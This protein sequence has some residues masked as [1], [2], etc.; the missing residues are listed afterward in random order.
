MAIPGLNGLNRAVRIRLAEAGYARFW[1]RCYRRTLLLLALALSGS[2]PEAGRPRPTGAAAGPSALP[3]AAAI[4]AQLAKLPLAFVPNVGQAGADVRYVSLGPGP[5]LELTDTEVRLKGPAARRGSNVVSLRLAGGA[6]PSRVE[7][8]DEL[9]GKVHHFDSNDPQQWRRDIPTFRR[10]TYRDVYPAT[11]LVFHGSQGAVEFD[12]VLRPG[13][14]PGAIGIDVRGAD[15]VTLD[16]EDVVI[17]TGGDT[18]RMHAP[19]V[20]QDSA[21]GRKLVDG[22][23]S[24][25]GSRIGFEIGAY[26]R[27]KPL[28]IDPVVTYSTYLGGMG[29]D[30][31]VGVGVDAA[32][33]IYT[34]NGFPGVTAPVRE[35]QRRRPDAALLRHPGR[36]AAPRARRRRRRQRVHRQLLP[37]SFP[38]PFHFDCPTRKPLTSPGPPMQRGDIGTYV[39]KLDPTGAIL[40]STSVGGNGHV[41]P[42]GIAIDEAG[43]MYVTAFGPA[44]GSFPLTRPPSAPPAASPRSSRPS[45]PT[46][47]AFS[48]WSGSSSSPALSPSTGPAPCT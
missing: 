43:N 42:G 45:P 38:S 32:G 9:P 26:D 44:A 20:Y 1:P 31:G 36:Y 7:S 23:F 22:R 34:A 10:V 29:P 18:L 33:N 46:T 8:Q 35:A 5:R 21:T 13:A 12:F 17:R 16:G 3:G 2:T 25:R 24:I 47:R 27:A 41:L 19:V 30:D 4:R 6:R 48:T 37:V 14:S 39:T 40:F 28:V 15:A 11:D